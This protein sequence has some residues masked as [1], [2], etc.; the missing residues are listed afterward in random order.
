M[1]RMFMVTLGLVAWA[2]TADTQEKGGSDLE[3]YLEEI[4]LSGISEM[5]RADVATIANIC[6]G[7]TLL[8]YRKDD[9]SGRY[10]P[11]YMSATCPKPDADPPQI[12][13]WKKLR[14]S[15]ADVLVDKL[16]PYAD[17]DGSGFVTTKEAGEF[18][19][20]VEFGYLVAQVNRSEGTSVKVIT[21]ASG[22]SPDEVAQKAKAYANLAGR[23]HDAGVTELPAISLSAN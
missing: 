12:E 19:R 15:D 9:A 14:R 1:N 4:R 5:G 23:I 6:A 16:K 13:M 11:G 2:V 22:Y 7:A 10:W 18:R 3:S 20:L 8:E 21:N 17:A